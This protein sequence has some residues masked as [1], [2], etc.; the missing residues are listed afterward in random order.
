MKT[1]KAFKKA[2]SDWTTLATAEQN[3]GQELGKQA[4]IHGHEQLLADWA[5]EHK[6][7]LL[8]GSWLM[9]ASTD[10]IARFAPKAAA[11]DMI[12]KA[13]L[14]TNS[15]DKDLVVFAKQVLQI[16]GENGYLSAPLT[17]GGAK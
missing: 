10:C 4:A 1:K 17:K 11:L 9:P 8:S 15:K 7:L 6:D 5:V 12:F 2:L 3:L 13:A 16:L 14:R